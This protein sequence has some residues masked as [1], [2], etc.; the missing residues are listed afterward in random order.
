MQAFS[1]NTELDVAWFPN[2]KKYLLPKQIKRYSKS[3][4]IF[5]LDWNCL[6]MSGNYHP[7]TLILSKELT[8]L[9]LKFLKKI[10]SLSLIYSE[11][12][13]FNKLR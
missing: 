10:K 6:Q 4:N 1:N 5:P 2:K 3:K 11:P 9:R 8:Q 13:C 7:M 12:L